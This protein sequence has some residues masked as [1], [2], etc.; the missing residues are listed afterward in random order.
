MDN[1]H[2]EKSFTVKELSQSL[3]F[4]YFVLNKVGLGPIVDFLKRT[5]ILD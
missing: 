5:G 2:V 4:A 3:H 1:V